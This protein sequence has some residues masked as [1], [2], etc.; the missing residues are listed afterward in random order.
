[1]S[2]RVVRFNRFLI[3]FNIVFISMFAAYVMSDYLNHS[4]VAEKITLKGPQGEILLELGAQQEGGVIALFDKQGVVRLQIQGGNTPAVMLS[5]PDSTLIGTL[6]TLQDGGAALG[7]GDQSGDIATFVRGGSSPNVAFY[8]HSSEP[9]LA[10]GISGSIPHLM[11]MPKS[12]EEKL[13][14]HGGSPASLLFVDENGDIPL[15]LSKH[16]LNQSKEVKFS[17]FSFGLIDKKSLCEL[18]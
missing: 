9:N 18:R 11:L 5:G 4:L 13:L 1:M 8:Q 15:A 7:L 17:S 6:F 10:L 16:G 2:H 14:I 3:V 12:K